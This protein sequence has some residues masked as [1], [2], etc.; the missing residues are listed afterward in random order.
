MSKSSWLTFYVSIIVPQ[1]PRTVKRLLHPHKNWV[2]QRVPPFL[3]VKL[4]LAIFPN[5][6]Q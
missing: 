1:E 2:P 5:L 6:V 3:I 4:F